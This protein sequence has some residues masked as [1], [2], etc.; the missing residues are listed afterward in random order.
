MSTPTPL[1]D[2]ALWQSQ[3]CGQFVFTSEQMTA[4]GRAEYLRGLEDSID[5]VAFNGG[6]VQIEAHIR[7]LKDQ[8]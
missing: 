8:E 6:S 7:A 2:W 4:Y 5:V 3:R 1:P